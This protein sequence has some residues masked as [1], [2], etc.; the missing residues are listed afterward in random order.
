MDKPTNKVRQKHYL[1]GR[2]K[3]QLNAWQHCGKGSPVA[4][5][6]CGATWLA[7]YEWHQTNQRSI[8]L[9]KWAQFSLHHSLLVLQHCILH[10]LQTVTGASPAIYSHL[11]RKSDIIRWASRVL[12]WTDDLNSLHH[13]LSAPQDCTVHHLQIVS[14]HK[15]TE[16]HLPYAVTCQLGELSSINHQSITANNLVQSSQL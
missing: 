13:S 14:H 10:D 4:L 7:S 3:N 2:G 16:C 8:A 6:H 9:N 5:S 11:L 1:L 12:Y 15:A